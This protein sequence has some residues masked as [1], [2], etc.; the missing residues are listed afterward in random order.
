MKKNQ[1][2]K[3][4]KLIIKKIALY[5]ILIYFWLLIF[6]YFSQKSMI[7]YPEKKDFYDCI[8]FEENEK[9]I[10]KS[11]RFYEKKW[12]KEWVIVFFHW[13]AWRVCDRFYIKSLLDKTG[14]SFIFVEYSGYSDVKNNS[15]DID[16]ILKNVEDIWEYVNKKYN[17]IYVLWRSLWTWPASYLTNFLKVEKLVLIS[18]Y[19]EFYK[20]GQDKYPYYPIKYLFTQNYNSSEYL[21]DYKW[22][23]LIIHGQKDITVPYELWKELFEKLKTEKK[24][25]ISLPEANHHNVFDFIVSSNQILDFFK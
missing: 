14:Y 6:L 24:Q 8:N 16:Y 12:E 2:I 23:I 1:K 9:K 10:Y 5:F 15:P 13:N 18:P 20:I 4:I 11:T 25:F 7:Y 21:K 19:W 22:E 17:K 3:L